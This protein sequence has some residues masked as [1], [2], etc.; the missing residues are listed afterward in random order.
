[1]YYTRI[2]PL[3]I[4]LSLSLIQ[5]TQCMYADNNQLTKTL[6]CHNA[7]PASVLC[8]PTKNIL[9]I[10]WESRVELHDLNNKNYFTFIEPATIYTSMAFNK[11][12][13]HFALATPRYI[14]VFNQ[15]DY[16][17]I[18]QKTFDG[19]N[20]SAPKTIIFS[21]I[22]ANE[23]LIKSYTTL[24][25]YMINLLTTKQPEQQPRPIMQGITRHKHQST[26][27]PLITVHPNAEHYVYQTD[28][29]QCL[30]LHKTYNPSF[31]IMMLQYYGLPI[32]LIIMIVRRII[33][34][35][36]S[37]QQLPCAVGFNKQIFAIDYSRNGKYI[38]TTEEDGI[39]SH[40]ENRPYRYHNRNK[41]ASSA[42]A[43]VTFH[44]NKKTIATLSNDRTLL[45]FL[46]L[47]TNK[48]LLEYP[49]GTEKITNNFQL[50]LKN[51]QLAFNYDG[52]II[53]VT[54]DNYCSVFTL[55]QSFITML[56]NYD[57]KKL[58]S[59]QKNTLSKILTTACPKLPALLTIATL[60]FLIGYFF[61]DNLQGR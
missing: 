9:A 2:V 1:M 3:F 34:Q 30:C 20:K 43:F 46:D 14:Q 16:S 36:I 21:P 22:Q 12:G 60:I 57:P 6:T 31:I 47:E 42:F 13:T 19:E 38:I 55:P 8:S 24:E 4:F 39:Y 52:T 32:E 45:H 23:L 28:S 61:F 26:S 54:H 35:N 37:Q 40:M 49:F 59:L 33:Y 58:P 51:K 48:Q 7:G 27:T 50:V 44:P 5:T 25:I 41:I 11:T 15:E 17:M 18:W 56:N 53:A 10:M 29:S